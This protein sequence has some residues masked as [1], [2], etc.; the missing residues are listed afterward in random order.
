MRPPRRARL[1]VGAEAA[2]LQDFVKSAMNIPSALLR[3]SVRRVWP[4][5]LAVALLPACSRHEAAPAVSTPRVVAAPT[6]RLSAQD[7]QDLTLIS[8]VVM[9]SNQVQVASRLMGYIRSVDVHE[10]QTVKAG[11]LLLQVDPNDIQGQVIQ[12]HSGLAQAEANLANAKADYVRFGNLFKDEAI[13]RQQWEQIQLRY[14][15]AQEQVA[16]AKAGYAMA[17]SQMRYASVTSPIDGVVVQKLANPGDLAA[18]GRPLL[19]IEGQGKL[20]VQVQVPDAVFP[21]IR[22]GDAVNVFAGARS[23]STRI[24]EAVPVADP[25]SHTHTVKLDVPAGA[26]LDSGSFVRAGFALGTASQLRVP[27]SAVVERAGMTGVFVVDAQGLAHF[28]LV[29]LGARVG[30]LVDV[31]AGLTPGDTVVTGKL[32]AVEN[33]VRIGGGDRG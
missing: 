19:V 13:P 20:Q 17:G 10:G 21:H 1:G 3:F 9:S 25:I 30:D 23:V 27:A 24:A 14:Q 6:V 26:G 22:I 7:K 11:Q 12:A 29:R 5:T 15:V 2:S 16:A 4:L 8:G 33:G 28:R 31:Q 32:D 18:P